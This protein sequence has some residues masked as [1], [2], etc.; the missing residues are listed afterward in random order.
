[1]IGVKMGNNQAFDRAIE[2]IN[3]FCPGFTHG[4]VR[5]TG[6]NNHP[7]ITITQQPQIDVIELKRQRH[8]HPENTG[9]DFYQ[10]AVFRRVGM[11]VMQRHG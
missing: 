11:R 5:E 1:M 3:D 10:R 7:A 8:T 4:I 9:S 6:I 2:D